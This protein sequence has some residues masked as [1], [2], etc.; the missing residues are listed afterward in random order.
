MLLTLRSA[1]SA[2]EGRPRES[3]AET[4]AAIA[5]GALMGGRGNSGVILSQWLRGFAEG[6]AGHETFAT[7]EFVLSLRRAAEAASQAVATPVERTK[8]T[9]ARRTA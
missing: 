1:E 2:L 7:H 9:L 8:L 5:R 3:A 4:T 6:M